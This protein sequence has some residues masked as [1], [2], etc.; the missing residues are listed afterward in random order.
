MG[1]DESD[2]T[3]TAIVA[4]FG[5]RTRLEINSEGYL[6]RLVDPTS[7][8]WELAY[9]NSGLLSAITDPRT[10]HFEF[11]YDEQGLLTNDAH[12]ACLAALTRSLSNN[13][14]KVSVATAEGRCSSYQ[15]QYLPS[16]GQLWVNTLADGTEHYL[17]IA[18]DGMRYLTNAD[19]STSAVQDGADPRFSM[20]ASF[21]QSNR[22]AT[23]AGLVSIITAQRQADT[24]NAAD[25]FSLRALTNTIALNGKSFV[26]R[27]DA[28]TRSFTG[29]TPE[30]RHAATQVDAQGRLTQL[31]VPGTASAQITYDARGRLTQ[32]A[33]GPRHTTFG[34]DP[35]TGYLRTATD[36]LGR[37]AAYQC[38]A[39]GRV[40]SLTLP[41]GANWSFAYDGAGNLLTLTEPNGTN[42]H[43]FTYTAQDLLKTYRSPLGVEQTFVYDKDEE[44]VRRQFP[45]GQGIDWVYNTKG[46]L[47][48]V[49]TPDGNDTLGYYTNGL[50]AQSVSRDGQRLDYAYD[51][52]LLTNV[53]W[54]GIVTGA[55]SYVLD[56]DFRVQEIR[57]AGLTLSNTFDADGLL[58]GVGSFRLA[59]H[60]ANGFLTNVSDGPFQEASEYNTN[61]E[62]SA[63]TVSHG[64]MLYRA[65]YSYDNLGQLTRKV[66]T[67]GGTTNTF[68][69]AYDPVGQLIRVQRDGILV[70]AYAY[71]AVGNRTGMT[72]T[73][74]G[75]ILVAADYE[76]DAD[77]KLLR[78][79]GRV[80][81]Y[82]ANGT[83]ATETRNGQTTTYHYNTDGTLAGVDLP[84]GRRVTYLHDAAGR[85][86]ARAVDGVRTHAWLYG[87][88]LLPLA[89][90][91]GTG[92]LRT[93]CIYAGFE[94][95]VAFVRN[96]V[97]NHIVTDHLGSPRLVVDGNGAVLKRVDYDAWGNVIL[98]SNPALDLAFGYAGGM[99]DADHTL[100]RFGA[101]DYLPPVGRWTAPHSVLEE[102]ELGSLYTYV[103]NEP[104]TSID[105]DGLKAKVKKQGNTVAKPH[106]KLV[107]KGHSKPVQK[108]QGK[109]VN[110]NDTAYLKKLNT[111]IKVE[112]ASG[113]GV[114]GTGKVYERLDLKR[115]LK[116]LS[117]PGDPNAAGPKKPSDV[118]FEQ[119]SNP[120]PKTPGFVLIG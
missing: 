53:T 113:I 105:P 50:V 19:G 60:G 64:A 86:I 109:T 74:T 107:Q 28:A 104:V 81:T 57:Y 3:P 4:P 85:R 89:E 29:V 63:V 117:P 88:G 94:T 76:Y 100:T 9:A 92:A 2:G 20:Q 119:E 65:E 6:C 12:V 48:L 103:G 120:P 33:Q 98:D 58:T 45:S 24:T 30:G 101:R 46:Q 1:E 95:P 14:V 71:D 23:P 13:T 59:Y 87:G 112:A 70:E 36:A 26:E 106:G 27:Y 54:S 79:G 39:L 16:G 72:N 55:V 47:T 90:C 22:L 31:D 44:L 67:M 115:I 84:D 8:V 110:K 62:L 5:Q 69:Y 35:D 49:Q 73:L 34:Y 41:D 21:A 43:R 102:G 80:F 15:I 75:Q 18:A 11:A 96:G 77:H 51:G 10:N 116:Q 66:E 114:V 93:T 97:T 42:Q 32:F 99:A 38:D 68:D 7:A 40:T 82:D 108:T 17:F 56:N 37:T 25:W 83:L 111:W 52:S 78:A 61:A 118:N 91:D